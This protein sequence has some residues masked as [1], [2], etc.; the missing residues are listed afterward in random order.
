MF[1]S[2]VNA[3]GCFR[4]VTLSCV[5]G[6]YQIS[7]VL[8]HN[9]WGQRDAITSPSASTS[10]CVCYICNITLELVFMCCLCLHQASNIKIYGAFLHNYGRATDTVRKCSASNAQFAD[11]TRDIRLKSLGGGHSQS[12]SLEDL[13]HKPVARVQ[14]NALVL[15]VSKKL[16]LICHVFLKYT[17]PFG[18]IFKTHTF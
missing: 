15:H 9:C 14:K 2:R 6:S 16:A 8:V 13:L 11:I 4:V 7:L 5:G 3:Q 18:S 1:L 12:L 17:A 10:T